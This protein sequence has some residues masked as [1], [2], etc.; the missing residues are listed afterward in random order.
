MSAI[1]QLEN[2]LYTHSQFQGQSQ[3]D[4]RFWPNCNLVLWN[5]LKTAHKI[6]VKLTE[7]FIQTFIEIMDEL[8]LSHGLNSLSKHCIH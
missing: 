8:S 3:L 5:T 4:K 1:A 6:G 7:H 2:K